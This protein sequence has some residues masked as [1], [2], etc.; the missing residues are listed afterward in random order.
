MKNKKIVYIGLSA[1]SIH[2]GHMNLLETARQYGEILIGLLS[3]KA[4]SQTKRLPNL[5]FDQ[6]K[7][8]LLNF[9]GV[10]KV[11]PQLESDYSHNIKKYKPG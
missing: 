2:H 4:I 5:N 3:D 9:K 6:R 7:K 11:V 10:I 8:I 1:D